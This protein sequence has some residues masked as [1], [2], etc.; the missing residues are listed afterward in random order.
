[1]KDER[2]N[3]RAYVAQIVGIS[4]GRAS[5]CWTTIPE[6]EFDGSQ[7]SLVAAEAV[8]QIMSAVNGSMVFEWA[9]SRERPPNISDPTAPSERREGE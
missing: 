5:M 2:E 1:M 9:K 7:A 8:D 3:L 6:G 4:I